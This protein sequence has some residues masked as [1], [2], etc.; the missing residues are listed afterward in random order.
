MLDNNA[1][2][3]IKKL[4]SQPRQG[5]PTD[6]F[7]A[8]TAALGKVFSAYKDQGGEVIRQNVFGLL[9]GQ[10]QDL[11]KSLNVLEK[12]NTGLQTDFNKNV[13]GAAKFGVQL[14][15]I[16]KKAG[17]NATKFKQYTGELRSVFAGQTKFYKDNDK[18]SN[19]LAKQSDIIRNQLGVSEDAYKNFVKYQGTAL[20]RS[21]SAD[22]LADNME[23]VN[24]QISDVAES[25]EGFYDGALTDMI[26]G[27][28]T[29]S[30]T[31]LA[32]FGQMPKSLGLA[33]LKSKSLGIELEKITG[34]GKGFL[35][36]ETAI[37]NEIEF[38]ILS[39]EELLTQDG[40]SLTN[41]FQK[42][43]IAQDANKQADLLVGFI[44]KYGEKLK[45][46]VYLQ[47]QSA[48]MLGLSTDDLFGAINQYNTAGAVNKEI[49]AKQTTDITNTGK[50]FD[51]QAK[52]EDKRSVETITQ[53]DATR[54]YIGT[55]GDYTDKVVKLQTTVKDLNTELLG[56][57]KAIAGTLA[58]SLVATSAYA[59]VKTY[60]TGLKVAN[61]AKK[62][63]GD[64]DSLDVGAVPKKDVFI[65][66]SSGK[67][68]VSGPFGAFSLDGRDDV[69]AAPNIR[70]AT[71]GGGD[72][73][74]VIAALKGMSFH[75]TNVFDG[76]KI[77]SSLQIRQG[78]Q[79]NNTNI[80]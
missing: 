33:I 57:A 6:P 3:L 7:D 9:A 60:D 69:L 80:V 25:V 58:N 52:I 28:G 50:T 4:K 40:K 2:Q 17:V 8:V 43:A 27:M 71:T 31:T 1:I 46:N 76:D 24:R 78:Q 75:V 79:L 38:Q 77:R 74:T 68:I 59:A 64:A 19:Q 53:D 15:T 67:T 61:A 42:A 32:T 14:D 37:A 30:A 47:E 18:F 51:Q 23:S 10:V 29:L 63:T 5:M 70:Q 55:L 35:D 72:T 16:A 65:P 22:A 56:D 41:E 21:N 11:N 49:F 54:A 66:A 39:G 62:G 20:G 48:Q 12:L 45:D 34:I 73:S 36:V 13:E 26:E 44:E